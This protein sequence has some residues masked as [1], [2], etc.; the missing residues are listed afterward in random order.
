ML[1][2]AND[3]CQDNLERIIES[4]SLLQLN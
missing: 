3:G 1:L 4:K 2:G